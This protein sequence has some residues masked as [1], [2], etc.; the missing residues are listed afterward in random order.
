M[1]HL[2]SQSNT[3]F[4][5]KHYNKICWALFLL[6][7]ILIFYGKLHHEM[8]LDE[9]QAVGIARC[10]KNPIEL[11]VLRDYEG[12]PYL[13]FLMLYI[14]NLVSHSNIAIQLFHLVFS[15]GAMY[16]LLVKSN[17][18]LIVKFLLIF[19]VY[20]IWEYTVINR[21]YGICLFFIFLYTYLITTQKLTL[22]YSIILF[23]ILCQLEA[24]SAAVAL[25]LGGYYFF[26]FPLSATKKI[27]FALFGML[28]FI[29]LYLSI[30][31]PI[32]ATAA[33]HSPFA[34]VAFDWAHFI[35]FFDYAFVTHHTYH[36]NQWCYL[37]F[38]P[39]WLTVVFFTLL[40]ILIFYTI[41]NNFIRLSTFVALI[42]LSYINLQITAITPRHLGFNFIIYLVAI[43][44]DKKSIK[45]SLCN[46]LLVPLLAVQAFWGIRLYLLDIKHP[47]TMAPKT[48]TFIK[49]NFPTQ[50]NIVG[51]G[52]M[53]ISSP[54]AYLGLPI[55]NLKT[56]NANRYYEWSQKEN[57][58]SNYKD[59]AVLANLNTIF[60]VKGPF[61]L[62]VSSDRNT[63]WITPILDSISITQ[64]QQFKKMPEF[65]G[66]IVPME[67]FYTY[68]QDSLIVWKSQGMNPK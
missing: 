28:N 46:Y 58:P 36:Y 5:T 1:N 22:I 50:K 65:F 26:T 66:A 53:S 27:I 31:Q 6:S 47:F 49:E 63:N 44:L 38:F 16:L 55:I 3:F 56:G 51:Y 59:T 23:T 13:Y 29:I 2:Q 62:I 11:F 20:F 7:S 24:Y 19:S 18:Q 37:Y 33:Y 12:H 32:D 57:L 45:T 30:Q 39:Q 9:W 4:F 8:W 15:V 14:V 60:K 17:F 68:K 42:G 34:M 61:V 48:C 54:S 21:V 43:W 67:N 41:K 10:A 25:L 64:N 35:R 52:E 40:L